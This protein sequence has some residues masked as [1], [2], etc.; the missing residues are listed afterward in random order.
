MSFGRLITAMATPFTADGALDLDGAVKLAS[1]LAD[2]GSEGI[3]ISGTT[4]E[5]PT[6]TREE[7]R[8]LLNAVIPAMRGR[9]SIIAGTGTYSTSES[10]ELSRDAHKAGADGLLL[11]TPYY[12]RPPQAGLAAHFNAIAKAVDLPVILYNVPPRTSCRIEHNTFLELSKTSNIV[13]VKDATG[14]VV[15]TAKL[16]RDLPQWTTWSGDD[17]MTLPMMAVGASGVI[18]VA[19]HLA[20]DRI[21]EMISAH[22]KG[23]RERAGAIHRDLLVLIDALFCTSSPIPLKAALAMCGLPGGPLRLPLIEATPDEKTRIRA[24]LEKLGII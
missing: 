11:V 17:A 22:E 19:S 23:D 20:G 7:K 9:V 15:G 24:A 10:I 6:T 18:S 5:S 16:A 1:H 3:V 13:G 14:D 12:S 21:S 8:E 4:G 2:H